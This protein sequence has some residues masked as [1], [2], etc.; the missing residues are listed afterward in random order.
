MTLDG[1]NS[2][3]AAPTIPFHVAR[4]YG[5]RPT[6][7]VQ[8]ARGADTIAAITPTNSGDAAASGKLDRLVGAVVPGRVSFDEVS[9]S[10]GL[11]ATE[12][13]G[14]PRAVLPF[15]TRPGDRQEAA[16][17]IQVGRR[18]DVAG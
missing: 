11:A 8:P 18:L 5:A 4:L 7:S 9:L 15:Y 6:A 17:A 1:S 10:G 14:A 13:G 3:S 2:L 16:T 12:R